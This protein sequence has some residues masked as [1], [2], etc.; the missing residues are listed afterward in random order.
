MY[1]HAHIT[2]LPSQLW[3]YIKV[4]N[5][6]LTR[7]LPALQRRY[8]IN[9]K[10]LVESLLAF[11]V[12]NGTNEALNS[13]TRHLRDS[14]QQLQIVLLRFHASLTM[15]LTKVMKDGYLEKRS[16]GLLQLWKK[17]RCVLTEDGIHLNDCKGEKELRFERMGTLDCVEY[18]AGSGVLHHRDERRQR[19]RLQVP[20]GGNGVERGDRARAG[21]LQKSRRR[22]DRQE[23]TYVTSGQLRGGRR[24]AIR[25]RQTIGFAHRCCRF[26]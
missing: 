6:S 5:G 15:S 26:I 14:H 21:A 18:T 16:N 4:G 24:R 3:L 25:V 2:G 1:Q 10:W 11:P 20:A 9:K 17:K 23:Q 13:R 8:V 19:D 22:S 7:R 12:K